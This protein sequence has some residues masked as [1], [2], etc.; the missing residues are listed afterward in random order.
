MISYLSN[1]CK[2]TK[3]Y[4]PELPVGKRPSLNVIIKH[5]PHLIHTL[6]S[7]WHSSG[8]Q[9]GLTSAA[10]TK[11]YH[12]SYMQKYLLPRR[13]PDGT[14]KRINLLLEDFNLFLNACSIVFQLAA[15]FRSYGENECQS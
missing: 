6:S 9:L 5:A 11:G 8:R 4:N 13:S 14:V 3:G 1:L 2:S 7:D 12:H 15:V 10:I